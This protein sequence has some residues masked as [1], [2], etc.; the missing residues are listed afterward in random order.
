LL[1]EPIPEQDST[2]DQMLA[3]VTDENVHREVE[4]GPPVGSEVW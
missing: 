1:I 2:L 4:T 3:G